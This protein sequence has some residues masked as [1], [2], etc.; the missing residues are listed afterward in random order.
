MT[1]EAKA[2][3]SW[4]ENK[5]LDLLIKK[6]Y[7]DKVLGECKCGSKSWNEKAEIRYYVNDFQ[8]K[9]SKECKKCGYIENID[10]T[11]VEWMEKD[12]K[13]FEEAENQIRIS[14]I[15]KKLFK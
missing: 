9:E 10:R 6:S 13:E 3:E 5:A 4:S 7:K 12:L 11:I 1:T 2:N 14:K 15:I 8:T